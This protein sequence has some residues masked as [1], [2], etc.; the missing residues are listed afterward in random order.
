MMEHSSQSMS[1]LELNGLIRQTLRQTFTTTYWVQAELSDVRTA[2]VGHC[3]LELIQKDSRGN[4]MLARARAI[5]WNRTWSSLRLYFEQTTGQSFSSGI[6][7]LVEVSVEFSELY[8][9]SL[10]IQNVDPNYTLG[11]IARRRREILQQLER[12]GVLTLNKELP[13]PA[14]LQRIAVIS[15][16]TA[17]GYEDFCRQLD[18]NPYGLVFYPRLFP[19]VMQGGQTEESIL[20]ALGKIADNSDHFDAVIII[21]GGGATSDLTG[22]DTYL[23]AASCAQFP[24]PVITGIGHERDDTVLDLVAHTRVKT[25]TAAAQFLVAHQYANLLH[26]NELFQK[27]EQCVLNLLANH[28]ERF[29]RLSDRVI[30]GI[31][32]R[33]LREQQR[34]I[35]MQQQLSQ[36]SVAL[37]TEENYRLRTFQKGIQHGSGILC[38]SHGHRLQL[39]EQRLK[40]LDPDVLLARG[41]SITMRNGRIVTKAAGLSEGDILVT[42][43]KDGKVKSIVRETEIEKS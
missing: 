29:R 7:V 18:E 25:P 38:T 40:A 13:L 20:A 1:L 9:Y 24:L 43:M 23:L 31:P 42:C 26:V 41:Y 3:Y 17:A 34:L 22:F 32:E 10:I 19:A 14:L 27:T 2:S 16:A 30:C 4:A 6:K 39:L 11:D 33:L 28:A 21:R 8:G 36:C 35:Q 5:I 15:S 12:E 37:L